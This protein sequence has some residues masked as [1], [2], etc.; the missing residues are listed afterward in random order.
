MAGGGAGAPGKYVKPN[1]PPPS[2]IAFYLLYA[3]HPYKEPG[4][5]DIA[6]LE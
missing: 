2:A 5:S 4:A 1:E 3:A 6:C